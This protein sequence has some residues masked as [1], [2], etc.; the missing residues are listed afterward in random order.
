MLNGLGIKKFAYDW[1]TEHLPG[2][3]REIQVLPEYNIELVAVW[4]WI[5]ERI[6]Y[7]IPEEADYIFNVLAETNTA[8]TIWAGF[9]DHFY[10]DKPEEEKFNTGVQIVDMLYKRAKETGSSIALYNHGGWYGE[11]ENQIKIIKAVDPD[12]IGIVYN[13]HYGHLHINR[14]PRMLSEML[15]YLW[16]VNINGMRSGGPK[17]LPVGEG[18]HE[19]E[20]IRVLI[21]S[22]FEGTIGIIGHT[23]GKDIKDVLIR[24]INGLQKI[25]KELDETEA[26]DT[27]R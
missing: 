18:E 21:D 25:L 11:P 1:R 17:I 14:F 5:D 13:F 22:G 6:V 26:L 9:S 2:F 16:T 23:E 3:P 19:K 15:P 27:Y 4:I 8:T 7:G 20:I 12:N 24:N 10:D